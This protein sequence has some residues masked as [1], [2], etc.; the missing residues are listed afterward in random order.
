MYAK[1]V[2][3]WLD[4]LLALAALVVLSP[5]MVLTALWVKLDSP[6]PVIFRQ[7]RVGKDKKYFQD[8]YKRQVPVCW[9]ASS[10]ARTSG[11]HT[12]SPWSMAS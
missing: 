11:M 4:A 9:A 7:K 10:W 3:R 12:G 2:K 5:V 8:V 1:Y 6:G